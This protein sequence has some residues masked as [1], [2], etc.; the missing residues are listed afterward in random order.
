MT[1]YKQRLDE[2]VKRTKAQAL[3]CDEYVGVVND[4]IQFMADMYKALHDKNEELQA[5]AKRLK[6]A[7]AV[8]S[9]QIGVACLKHDLTHALSCG[10]CHAE[11]SASADKM[12]EALEFYGNQQ[13]WRS[14]EQVN[15]DE[16]FDTA[17][18]N[19]SDNHGQRAREALTTY[20]QARGGES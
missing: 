9:K 6:E 13:N 14:G 17:M 16:H 15:Y 10:H 3:S 5:E 11:L 20:E 18:S 2:L 4:S 1:D 19:K 8:R 12:K 7:L